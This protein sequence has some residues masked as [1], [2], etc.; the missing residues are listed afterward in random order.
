MAGEECHGGQMAALCARDE[1][2]F[3]GKI[4]GATRRMMITLTVR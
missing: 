4:G 2:I 1:S 3:M